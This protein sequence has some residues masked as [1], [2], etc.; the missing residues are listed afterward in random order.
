MLHHDQKYRW[1]DMERID[2]S[3]VSNLFLS[4]ELTPNSLTAIMGTL[5][6]I[7][8]ASDSRDSDPEQTI[9]IHA[10]YAAKLRSRYEAYDYG[11]FSGSADVF[12]KLLDQ[13]ESYEKSGRS[14]P[15]VVHGDPVMSNI[16][17]NSFGK[18]KLI[19]MRGQL[20]ESF[21]CRGDEMY[22]WGKLFQSLIGYDEILQ[23]RSIPESYRRSLVEC[24]WSNLRDLSPDARP[25]DIKLVTRSLL[26]SLLP[27]HT[28]QDES[29]KQ[30][31]YYGLI[32]KCT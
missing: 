16:L 3:V 11:R 4:E 31:A 20:G 32:E 1:Y 21:S 23:S 26:F 2:G 18:V 24:F 19:D 30:L 8:T 14:R 12:A 5:H 17:I 10:N 9:D 28:A 25:G 27:L 7:H 29:E 13:L 6:R 15:A 22:D